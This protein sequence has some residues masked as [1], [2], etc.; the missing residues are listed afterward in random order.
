MNAALAKWDVVVAR[1]GWPRILA[2]DDPERGGRLA[3]FVLYLLDDTELVSASVRNYVWGCHGR[4]V[5]EL[6]REVASRFV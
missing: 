1:H 3:T 6:L 5:V 4:Q 2:T